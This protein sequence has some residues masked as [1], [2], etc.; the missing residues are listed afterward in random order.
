MT[1]DKF[2]TSCRYPKPKPRTK[3]SPS[4]FAFWKSRKKERYTT[5]ALPPSLSL[6]SATAAWDPETT[7]F[8]V[9]L[10]LL[11]LERT[12]RRCGKTIN[13]KFLVLLACS[14]WYSPAQ[15]SVYIFICAPF[16]LSL[17][18]NRPLF[19]SL[20]VC[21]S[22]LSGLITFCRRGG[23]RSWLQEYRC[24]RMPISSAEPKLF[25]PPDGL[26]LAF[27][28]CF[29]SFRYFARFCSSLSAH[30]NHFFDPLKLWALKAFLPRCPSNKGRIAAVFC[31][32]ALFWL[33]IDFQLKEDGVSRRIPK[34]GYADDMAASDCYRSS[35]AA[36]ENCWR[37]AR[38]V[39]LQ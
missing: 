6:L 5:D 4:L 25:P 20:V 24:L 33:F 18:L 13:D 16:P 28:L 15:S 32:S 29:R 31:P 23:H 11:L 12:L 22:A 30:H 2:L 26:F 14:C 27:S 19:F 39:D 3:L 8:L 35:E 1:M 34:I 9:A 21:S 7:S 37:Q 10:L 36:L 38:V 17:S